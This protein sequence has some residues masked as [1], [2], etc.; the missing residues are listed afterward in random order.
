MDPNGLLVALG[1]F[2]L[3]QQAILLKSWL[4]SGM[5]KWPGLLTQ[6][7]LGVPSNEVESDRPLV[8]W[9]AGGDEM[10]GM[11]FRA[12]MMENGD[13]VILLLG[14]L[15]VLELQFP[16]AFTISCAGRGSVELQSKNTLVIQ[17]WEPLFQR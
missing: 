5:E 14:K 6:S 1:E 2:L 15:D 7:F 4:S 12:T 9:G 10:N 11:E 17:G 16:E 13:E 3:P 8:Y